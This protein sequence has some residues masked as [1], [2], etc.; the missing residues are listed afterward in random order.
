MSKVVA[1]TLG[2][3]ARLFRPHPV[4]ILIPFAVGLMGLVCGG[5]YVIFKRLSWL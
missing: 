4:Y 1:T 3:D 2:P 5:L